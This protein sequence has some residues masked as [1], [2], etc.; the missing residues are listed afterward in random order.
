MAMTKAYLDYVLDQLREAGPVEIKRMFGGAGL[1]LNGVI[2]ALVAD[3]VLYFKV[4]PYNLAD[5]EARGCG[6]FA[7]TRKDGTPMAGAGR[8]PYRAVPDDILE[9]PE[10]LARWA[11]KAADR[12]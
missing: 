5:Y 9:D 3:D 12:A 4:G 6:T 10:N 8:M 1:Y 11:R 7:P 2:F